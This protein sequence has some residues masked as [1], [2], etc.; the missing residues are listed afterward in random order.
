GIAL[1]FTLKELAPDVASEKDA[2]PVFPRLE[3]RLNE[4]EPFLALK[5]G[6]EVGFKTSVYGAPPIEMAISV[7]GSKMMVPPPGGARTPEI[8]AKTSLPTRLNVAPSTM[9]PPE[10]KS[11]FPATL[12]IL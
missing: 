6:V 8:T 11:S 1:V 12:P 7:S 10:T 2:M 3:L 5:P 9:N 4:R